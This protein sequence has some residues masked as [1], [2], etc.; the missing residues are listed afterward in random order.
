MNTQ[1]AGRGLAELKN[2]ISQIKAGL[3]QLGPIP[4]DMPEMIESA[5]LLRKNEHL[6]KSDTAKSEL[7]ASYTAYTDNLETLLQSVFEIQ[8]ELK[9][10]I[11][12]QNR[13]ISAKRR[14]RRKAK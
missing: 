1:G 13:L 4:I 11:H 7:I 5:N 14:V 3:D 6:V 9:D 12:D 8:K 2:K 10:I